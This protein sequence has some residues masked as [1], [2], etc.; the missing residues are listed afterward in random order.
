MKQSRIEKIFENKQIKPTSVR[1]LVLKVFMAKDFAISMSDIENELPWSDRATIFRTLQTFERN[2]LIHSIDD[3]QKAKKY[4]LCS[5]ECEFRH[6]EIHPHFHCEECHKTLCVPALNFLV[7]KLPED[8]M[9]NS[10]SLIINGICPDCKS[11]G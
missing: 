7:P 8:Y 1:E 9:I 6:H 2:A 11:Q 10:Y 4:A 3:G 5:D